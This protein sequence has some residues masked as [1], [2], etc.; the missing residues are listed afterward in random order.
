MDIFLNDYL[1]KPVLAPLGLELDLQPRTTAQTHQK[2]ARPARITLIEFP[3]LDN[4]F[5]FEI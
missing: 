2:D 3:Q 4:H 1:Q 5:L